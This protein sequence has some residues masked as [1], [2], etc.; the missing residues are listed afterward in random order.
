M[1]SRTIIIYKCPCGK[2]LPDGS[3]A[4]RRYCND[5]KNDRQKESQNRTNRKRAGEREFNRIKIN[6][7]KSWV[8]WGVKK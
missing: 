4:H 5:C 6:L 1:N 3:I 8:M 2:A 7:F